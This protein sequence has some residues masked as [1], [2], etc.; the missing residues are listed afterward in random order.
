MLPA[1]EAGFFQRE[2]AD[3]VLPLPAG[4]RP[5]RR[6]IVG[7][8]DYQL[9]EPLEIPILRMDPQGEARHL[10]RLQRVRRERDQQRWHE[11]MARLEQACRDERRR[12]RCRRSWTR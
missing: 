12:T 7:V 3:C 6:T 2:I 4:D 11:A 9:D 5:A 10:A 1:I 8:N